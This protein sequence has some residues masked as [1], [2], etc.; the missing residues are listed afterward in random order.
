MVLLFGSA[1]PP[2][3]PESESIAPPSRAANS[4]T[5]RRMERNGLRRRHRSMGKS[6]ATVMVGG[7]HGIRRSSRACCGMVVTTRLLDAALL[8]GVKEAGVKVAV[9]P[10]G[11]PEALNW[12]FPV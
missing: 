3:Q 6:S 10:G 8:P 7:I 5:L 4:S 11:R 9:E 2:P 1:R 12:M